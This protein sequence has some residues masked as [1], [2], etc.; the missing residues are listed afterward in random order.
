MLSSHD[1]YATTRAEGRRGGSA[2]QGDGSRAKAKGRPGTSGGS[3]GGDSSS[4]LSLTDERERR[5]GRGGGTPRDDAE[6]QRAVDDEDGGEGDEDSL[7]LIPEVRASV[8]SRLTFS[9]LSA[10]VAK[11]KRQSLRYTDLFR[12]PPWNR[13]KVHTGT[14]IPV[15]IPHLRK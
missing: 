7:E 15:R 3:C 14:Y 12:L 11:G 13:S 8:F 5:R 4:L 2:G 9:W 10:L 1:S 6:G